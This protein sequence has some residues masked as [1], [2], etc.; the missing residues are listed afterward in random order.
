[1]SQAIHDK[2]GATAAEEVSTYAQVTWRLIP[3]LFV[4]YVI[5]YLDRVNVGFAKL[6]M[7]QDLHFS[8]AVYGLGAGIFF[9][10]YCSSEV[11]ANIMLSRLGARRWLTSIMVTWGILSACTMFVKTPASF[12]ILRCLL[13]VAESG[14]FPGVIYYLTLWYPSH[15]RGRVVAMFMTAQPLSGV[16]GGPL[17]GWILQEFHD[18]GHLRG[19]QWLF[20]LEGM[21]AVVMGLVLFYWIDN[22]IREAHW[23]SEEQKQMLE[24]HIAA[25]SALKEEH[26]RIGGLIRDPRVWLLSAVTLFAVIGMYGI[27]FWLPTIIK[28]TGVERPLQVGLLTVIPY[29]TAVVA[30]NLAGRS[31][32]R[33]G[34]RRWHLALSTIVAGLGLVFVTMHAGN[35]TL[36]LAGLTAAAAGGFTSQALFW[37][38]P[39]GVLGG[40]AAA[41]GI[42]LIN[43]AGNTGGF[44]G[45][46]LVGWISD[47]THSTSVGIYVLATCFFLASALTFLVPAALVNR[48]R[49]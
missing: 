43:A 7:L 32:D 31:S 21:P 8:E 39:T 3:L 23:L 33:T 44:I 4:C 11:P 38:L 13:G 9:V 16:I 30:M 17:S 45:P 10:G 26:H 20:L 29:G 25:D 34:E 40:T 1:M 49:E 41:A 48:R 42:A 14:M 6:Q 24:E 27:V 5:A 35:T 19:W 15:R 36:A 18:V 2:R 22:N 47:A 12:Y 28:A 46:Y 37:N